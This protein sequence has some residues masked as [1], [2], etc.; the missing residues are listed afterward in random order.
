MQPAHGGRIQPLVLKLV[1]LLGQRNAAKQHLVRNKIT[2]IFGSLCTPLLSSII[3]DSAISH[4][5]LRVPVP[6]GLP[7]V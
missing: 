4:N 7:V 2:L 5:N 1:Q 6:V 3:V